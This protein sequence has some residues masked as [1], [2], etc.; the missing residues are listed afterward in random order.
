MKLCYK[1]SDE[2]VEKHAACNSSILVF[3][4]AALSTTSTAHI[5]S[6]PLVSY[7]LQYIVLSPIE[8]VHSGHYRK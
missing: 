6:Y 4:G 3:F 7:H 1:Q 8:N 2:L 5:A